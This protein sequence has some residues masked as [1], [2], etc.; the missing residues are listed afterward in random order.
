MGHEVSCPTSVGSVLSPNAT[1]CAETRKNCISKYK[2]KDAAPPVY[3]YYQY[4][5]KRVMRSATSKRGYRPMYK[6]LRSSL[7]DPNFKGCIF[8]VGRFG[9][10]VLWKKGLPF[11]WP[12]KARSKT[13]SSLEVYSMWLLKMWKTAPYRQRLFSFILATKI[14]QNLYCVFYFF[15]KT[16]K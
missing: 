8:F 12:L 16:E 14:Q 4:H 1:M 15:H 2:K 13:K 9:I 5:N 3:N 11:L 10:V 7:E 6:D